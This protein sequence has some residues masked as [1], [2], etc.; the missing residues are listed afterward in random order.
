MLAGW[1]AISAIETGN[2]N[3]LAS[4]MVDAQQLF[5]NSVPP[6]KLHTIIGFFSLIVRTKA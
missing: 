3:A 5:D 1:N 2:I 6:Y 4:S